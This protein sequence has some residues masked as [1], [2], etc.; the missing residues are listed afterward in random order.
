[1]ELGTGALDNGWQCRAGDRS[2]ARDQGHR[3]LASPPIRFVLFSGEEQGTVGSFEYVK[4]HRAELDKIRRMITYDSASA[5]SA[6]YSL[7]GAAI[8]KPV[9]VRC[10][11]AARILGRERHTYDAS[12]GTD[13]FDFL[14]EEM[15]TLSPP[16]RPTTAKLPRASTRW[17]KSTWQLK[18]HTALAAL[19]V[20]A[21]PTA[22][23]PLA[24]ASPAPS[25]TFGKE[26]GSTT[27]EIA[28]LLGRVAKR[29]ARP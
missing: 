7:G 18:L 21:S 19:T 3:T 2:R 17:T 6:G 13:N 27:A 4:A 14:L 8:S 24:S 15:P 26:T 9:S 5:A 23:K 20:W 12:F 16:E 29:P 10:F 28:G 1:L 11:E 25:S 22:P